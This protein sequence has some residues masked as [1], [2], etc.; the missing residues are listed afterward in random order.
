MWIHDNG[1]PPVQIMAYRNEDKVLGAEASLIKPP[2]STLK[3]LGVLRIVIEKH[4]PEK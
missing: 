3:T 1:Q 2:A 4:S